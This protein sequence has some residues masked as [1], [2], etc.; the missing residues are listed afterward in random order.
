MSAARLKISQEIVR[1]LDDALAHCNMNGS[2]HPEPGTCGV[3]AEH[4]EA[5]RVYLETWIA[6]P[7]SLAIAAINGEERGLRHISGM[8]RFPARIPAL[9]GFEAVLLR[10][11]LTGHG[12]NPL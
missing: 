4:R 9:T 1:V 8:R 12:C 11:R 5:M 2:G 3:D 6:A 7:L 10:R